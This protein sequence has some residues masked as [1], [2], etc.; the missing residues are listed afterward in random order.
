MLCDL[1]RTNCHANASQG[2]CCRLLKYWGCAR[3]PQVAMTRLATVSKI[4][5]SSHLKL[6]LLNRFLLSPVADRHNFGVSW[7]GRRPFLSPTLTVQIF[8][9]TDTRSCYFPTTKSD[10]ASHFREHHRVKCQVTIHHYA[11]DKESGDKLERGCTRR[12]I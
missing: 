11:L 2:S 4:P 1:G 10:A 12:H 9:S 5:L 6:A 3:V 7:T 8:E